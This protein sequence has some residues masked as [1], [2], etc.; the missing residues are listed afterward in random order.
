[1]NN[2]L[3]KVLIISSK[4]P[5]YSAG[6]GQDVMKS[7]QQVGCAVDYITKYAYN[8]TIDNVY[9][10]EPIPFLLQ[11]RDRLKLI[12]GD[13]F[14]NR[15]IQILRKLGLLKTKYKRTND[16]LIVSPDESISPIPIS[17]VLERIKCEYDCII[18]L[19]W[20]DMINST[21]LKEIYGVLKCP[22]LI[23]AV[24]MAPMTGG[25]Y[26]FGNCERYKMGCGRCVGLNSFDS[27]D[28]SYKNYKL[29]QDNYSRIKCVFLG[30]TWMLKYAKD[31]HLF[32]FS[33]IEK[34]N[35]AIDENRFR[36]L[37]V[38]TAR[39]QLAIKGDK[40]FII[41]AR[42]SSLSR[43]GIEYV[44]KAYTQFVSILNTENRKKILLLTVG[45]SYIINHMESYLQCMHL[46]FVDQHTL[47][48]AYQAAN[49]FINASIDDA[50]PSM[51]NQS[52]LCGT[53]VVCFDNG[54]A[55]DV[56]ENGVS[57]YKCN[58]KDIGGLVNGLSSIYNMEKKDY[59]NFR[60]TTRE[61]GIAMNSLVAFSDNII[62]IFERVIGS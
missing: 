6:L 40:M 18:T 61:K 35:I 45:D 44:I 32:D 27:F 55:L 30:N 58:V 8:G 54:T 7:L 22:I 46:G 51:I 24:D 16:I 17:V 25:C 57:G 21:L 14:V 56:I 42:S 62:R 39:S 34:C 47:T 2:F 13:V 29:K 3:K 5:E 4:P 9:G 38:N 37:D 36:P 28:Q 15:F 60:T 31:S 1:M 19:F 10:V 12:L 52:I 33:L 23:Y 50:G 59:L 49:V 26:Y 11:I 43:K 48:L 41:L 53:P 20:Q